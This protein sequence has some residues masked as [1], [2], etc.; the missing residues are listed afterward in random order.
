MPN[1]GTSL[2]VYLQCMPFLEYQRKLERS[3]LKTGFQIFVNAVIWLHASNQIRILLVAL[4]TLL[5]CCQTQPKIVFHSNRPPSVSL[6]SRLLS[7]W[8][9]LAEVC[10]ILDLMSI[11]NKKCCA[12]IVK[13]LLY[14][15]W[16][17]LGYRERQA[18]ILRLVWEGTLHSSFRNW[19]EITIGTKNKERAAQAAH[20]IF[21]EHKIKVFMIEWSQRAS[22]KLKVREAIAKLSSNALLRTFI[23]WK[24]KLHT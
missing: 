21:R 5:S 3:N 19:L 11:S 14:A 10:F 20:S 8:G 2:S 12:P 1:I 9:L 4:W 17:F 7:F 18:K 23:Q 16:W 22:E 24:V 6:C 13:R 15:W